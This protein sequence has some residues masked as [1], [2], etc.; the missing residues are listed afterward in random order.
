[1]AD[2]ASDIV[3]CVGLKH[4][5]ASAHYLGFMEE[6][7]FYRQPSARAEAMGRGR[8]ANGRSWGSCPWSDFSVYSLSARWVY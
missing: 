5:S 4:G 1:M 3:R 8:V 2:K 6:L 7:F